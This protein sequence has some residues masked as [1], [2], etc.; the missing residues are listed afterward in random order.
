MAL[1]AVKATCSTF[2]TISF[3]EA[4]AVDDGAARTAFW[5]VAGAVVGSDVTCDTV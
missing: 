3:G 2:G 5:P 1:D 4:V